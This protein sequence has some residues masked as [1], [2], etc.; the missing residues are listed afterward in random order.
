MEEISDKEKKQAYFAVMSQWKI[1]CDECKEMT[2]NNS[3]EPAFGHKE[4]CS[5]YAHAIRMMKIFNDEAY[6]NQEKEFERMSQEDEDDRND[7][8][9]KEWFGKF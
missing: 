4:S 6:K 7:G 8:S 3:E 2:C 9:V 5:K 1:R